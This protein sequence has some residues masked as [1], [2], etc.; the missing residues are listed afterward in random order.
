MTLAKRTAL[1]GVYTAGLIAGTLG[2]WRMLFELARDDATAS[3]VVL[4]PF[5]TLVLLYE[6]RQAILASSIEWAPMAGGGVIA[7]G[8]ALLLFGMFHHRSGDPG[9]YLSI[10]TAGIVVSWLGGFLLCYGPRAVRAALFPLLFLAF[11]IPIPAAIVRSA[12][13]FLKTG[14]AETVAALFTLT[15]TPY[16][17]EGFVFSLP[18]FVIEIADEC[19]GIRSSIALLLTALLAGHMFLETWW[20]KG[21]LVLAVIPLALLKNGIRIVTLSLLARYVNPSFLTGQLHHEGGIVFFL[22]TL[23]IVMPLFTL[24]RN[25]EPAFVEETA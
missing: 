19:S 15:G 21:I 1:V 23:A 20:K 13:L 17:R 24:L 7:T 8:M 2:V 3:H 11:T 10:V 5:V 22:L 9:N 16:Y 4:V 25:S 14:S 12:T 18:T 6:C